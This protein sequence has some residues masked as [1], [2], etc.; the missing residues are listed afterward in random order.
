MNLL[1]LNGFGLWYGRI[2]KYFTSGCFP[3]RWNWARRHREWVM[4][5]Y[6]ER[7]GDEPYCLVG[8]S[9]GGTLAHEVA[10][11]DERCMALIVHSGMWRSPKIVQILPTLLLVTIGDRTPT[12]SATRQ[13]RDAYREHYW[14][15]FPSAQTWSP[16]ELAEL[17]KTTWHGH[18]FANGLEAME[19]WCR[20]K[21][22][23]ELPVAR[24]SA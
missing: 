11:A 9:D 19:T 17:P 20:T 22:D 3:Y 1:G 16:Y 2:E 13:A 5:Y 21:L 6:T 23:Y 24:G 14:E 18:E 10:Q 8:F 12:N 4:D 15:Q 7:H